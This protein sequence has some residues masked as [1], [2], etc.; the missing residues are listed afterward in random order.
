MSRLA[1]HAKFRWRGWV[2]RL[3]RTT[4]TEARWHMQE[5]DIRIRLLYRDIQDPEAPPEWT[6]IIVMHGLGDMTGAGSSPDSA[7]EA[8]A[9]AER[10]FFDKVVSAA[11]LVRRL[12]RGNQP[13]PEP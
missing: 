3:E 2:F 13:D 7:D 8:L 6:A 1:A 5:G 10:D 9:H 12:K 11:R 4:S